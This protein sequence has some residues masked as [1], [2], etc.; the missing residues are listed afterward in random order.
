MLLP[1][2]FFAVD[3]LVELDFGLLEVEVIFFGVLPLE[4]GLEAAALVALK[5]YG[6]ASTGATGCS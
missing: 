5:A 2:D 4:L 1:L 3:F 6:S